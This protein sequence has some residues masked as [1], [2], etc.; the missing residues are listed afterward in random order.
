M[1]TYLDRDDKLDSGTRST[2]P[3]TVYAE[4]WTWNCFASPWMVQLTVF[5]TRFAPID[6]IASIRVTL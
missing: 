1:M 2:G 4:N 6:K 5:F 3:S